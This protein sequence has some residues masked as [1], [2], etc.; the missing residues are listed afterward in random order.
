MHKKEVH[1]NFD[2]NNENESNRRLKYYFSKSDSSPKEQLFKVIGEA[3]ESID[4]AIYMITDNDFVK[5]LC[6]ATKRG[7]KVR[8][9]AD[10]SVDKDGSKHLKA[11][12]RLLEGRIPIKV[13]NYKG[14]MHLKNMIIDQKIITT[15]SYNFTYY[16]E[17]ENEEVVIISRDKKIAK[18][19]TEKFNLMWNDEIR[20]STYYPIDRQQDI[21]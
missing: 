19:W 21:A 14:N 7:V 12:D 11:L 15:G 16:A 20:Y 17:K 8:I 5:Q 13:N 18:E 3:D 1:P 9:I 6:F 10:K 4:V 2:E